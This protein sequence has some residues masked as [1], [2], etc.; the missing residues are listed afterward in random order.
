MLLLVRNRLGPARHG[1]SASLVRHRRLSRTSYGLRMTDVEHSRK[2]AS[3][4]PA[5]PEHDANRQ[6]SLP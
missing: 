1:A 2:G 3:A 6:R 5:M 4:G